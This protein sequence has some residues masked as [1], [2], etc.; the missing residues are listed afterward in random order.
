M[1][2][3]EI[4]AYKQSWRA[5]LLGLLVQPTVRGARPVSKQTKGARRTQNKRR[6]LDSDPLAYVRLKPVQTM[7]GSSPGLCSKNVLTLGRIYRRKLK[8]SL[9]P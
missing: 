7:G 9:T 6:R 8:R 4:A 2:R 5:G 1:D 3:V